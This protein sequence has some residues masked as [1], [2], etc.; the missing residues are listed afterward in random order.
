[1]ATGGAGGQAGH[2]TGGTGTGGIGGG[3]GVHGTGGVGG[4]VPTPTSVQDLCQLFCGRLATCDTARDQQTCIFTCRDSNS[5]LFPNLR[6]ELVAGIASCIQQ[7]DCATIDRDTALGA[8]LTQAAATV[9]PSSAGTS[10]CSALQT[11]DAQCGVTMNQT[12]C[13]NSIKIYSDATVAQAMGCTSKS[14]SLIYS[15]ASATVGQAS[16]GWSLGGGLKPGQK[17]SGTAETCNYFSYTQASCE[18]VGCTFSSTCTG[19]PYCTYSY[20]SASCT[21]IAGCTWST[22]TASCTGTP[23]VTCAS[24]TTTPTTC[25]Q[26]VGCFLNTQC[27]GTTPACSTLSVSACASHGGCSVVD[28]L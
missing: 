15:C 2:A 7:D 9:A 12:D 14:C 20:G 21:A 4:A 28:A 5:A 23:T 1:M 25:Q 27:T 22:T 16:G 11:A 13:L 6:P 24:L 19:T 3:A 17:C 18:A 26:N 8:C 10:F